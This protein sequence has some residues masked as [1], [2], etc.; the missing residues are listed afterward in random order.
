MIWIFQEISALSS[1]WYRVGAVRPASSRH[2]LHGWVCTLYQVYPGNRAQYI[3][4]AD[5][6]PTTVGDLYDLYG[7]YDLYDLPNITMLTLIATL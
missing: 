3:I 7:L 4:T 1:A 5:T 2:Y 6:G